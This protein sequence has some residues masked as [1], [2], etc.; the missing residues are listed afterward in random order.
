MDIQDTVNKLRMIGKDIKQHNPFG[1]IYQDKYGDM[2]L[3]KQTGSSQDNIDGIVQY[4][5]GKHFIA[6]DREVEQADSNK[7]TRLRELYIADYKDC[8]KSAF[9]IF[10]I[11]Y[12]NGRYSDRSAKDIQD[13][14]IVVVIDSVSRLYIINYSGKILDIS[15]HYDHDPFKSLVV[16]ENKDNT[17]A[18]GYEASMTKKSY[19]PKTNKVKQKLVVINSYNFISK[20]DG[21]TLELL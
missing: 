7:I 6:I 12:P 11:I 1:L 15:K 18:I 3:I 14:K 19:E 2:H 17:Y 4:S 8:I 21:D 20:L 16:K 5:M 9:D 13:S 10:S